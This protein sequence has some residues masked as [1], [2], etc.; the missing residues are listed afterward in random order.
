[1][2]DMQEVIGENIR[3]IRANKKMTQKALAEKV[4]V[5]QQYIS[6]LEQ[7]KAMPAIPVLSDIAKALGVSFTELIRDENNHYKVFVDMTDK[8]KEQMEQSPPDVRGV[9]QRAINAGA[10]HIIVEISITEGET[11]MLNSYATSNENV[12]GF[13]HFIDPQGYQSILDMPA[14]YVEMCKKDKECGEDRVKFYQWL[15]GQHFSDKTF[16]LQ[17]GLPRNMSV[18]SLSF[19]DTLNLW[20]MLGI[21]SKQEQERLQTKIKERVASQMA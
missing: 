18:A 7:G 19:E 21:I 12:V 11:E 16:C 6:K 9:M 14:Q 1:M 8:Y 17:K 3:T 5:N 2:S 10:G 4:F 20:R 13:W 15:I